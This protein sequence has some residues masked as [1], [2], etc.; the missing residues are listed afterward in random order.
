MLADV[1]LASL[2]VILSKAGSP[3]NF[4]LICPSLYVSVKGLSPQLVTFVEKFVKN[5][6]VPFDGNPG[7]PLNQ[8]TLQLGPNSFTQTLD[9]THVP[10]T[11]AI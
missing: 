7:R 3:E 11:L 1:V 8:L 5:G 2:N 9:V 4:I 6:D 10:Q